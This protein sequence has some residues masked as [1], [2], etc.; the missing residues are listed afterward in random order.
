MLDVPYLPI[1]RNWTTVAR[2][3]AS[4]LDGA[5]PGWITTSTTGGGSVTTET[6][7][8]GRMRINTGTTATGDGATIEFTG[9]IV[10]IEYDAIALTAVTTGDAGGSVT[11]RTGII[12]DSGNRLEIER[13]A[14]SINNGSYGRKLPEKDH[15]NHKIRDVALWW[16]GTH[17]IQGI[18]EGMSSNPHMP[19][20]DANSP[21]PSLTYTPKLFELTTQDTAADRQASLH[22]IDLQLFS[23][24]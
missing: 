2:Y 21:D 8:G 10:P 4:F 19:D 12:A 16:P 17:R 3:E 1:N 5:A 9:D 13:E 7:D 24:K 18:A 23:S 11:N 6:T 20:T 15:E 22:Y 14:N